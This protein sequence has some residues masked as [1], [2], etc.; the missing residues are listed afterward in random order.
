MQALTSP[1]HCTR[2][3]LAVLKPTEEAESDALVGVPAFF[4][5]RVLLWEAA[6]RSAWRFLTHRHGGRCSQAMRPSQIDPMTKAIHRELK[7]KPYHCLLI[8]SQRSMAFGSI[9]PEHRI[10]KGALRS[11]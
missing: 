1:P 11:G 3:D 8:C 10:S 7:K 4:Y 9:M 6:V 5:R 2:S